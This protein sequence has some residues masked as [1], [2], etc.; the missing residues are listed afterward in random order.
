MDAA[1]WDPAPFFFFFGS[2]Y[3][4]SSCVMSGVYCV[5][6]F[7]EAMASGFRLSETVSP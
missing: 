1:Q 2:T 6:C 7:V 3:F 5:F 4:V